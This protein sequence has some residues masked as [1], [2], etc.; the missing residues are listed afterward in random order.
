[1]KQQ[2][3][4]ENQIKRPTYTPCIDNILQGIEFLNNLLQFPKE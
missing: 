1:M 3:K 2:A 4:R